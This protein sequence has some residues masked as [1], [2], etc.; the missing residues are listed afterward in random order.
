MHVVPI[1]PKESGAILAPCDLVRRPEFVDEGLS[2]AHVRTI[3]LRTVALWGL[4]P[5]LYAKEYQVKR[6]PPAAVSAGRTVCATGS[7]RQRGRRGKGEAGLS[8]SARPHRQRRVRLRGQAAH[9]KR[10]LRI[11]WR[12]ASHRAPRARR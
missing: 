12:I 10:P 2:F 4:Y 9:R 5:I 8:H 1:D 3:Y 7:A 6:P 11:L